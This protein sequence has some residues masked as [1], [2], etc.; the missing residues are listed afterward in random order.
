MQYD[1]RKKRIAP[2]TQ[3]TGPNFMLPNTDY[4]H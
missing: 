2:G 4:A 3:A 1:E